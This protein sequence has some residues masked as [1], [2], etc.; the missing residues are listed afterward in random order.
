MPRHLLRPASS[1]K[2][3]A[4]SLFC[5]LCLCS[6]AALAGQAPP[7]VPLPPAP[8]VKVTPVPLI[9]DWRPY[10]ADFQSPDAAKREAAI[11]V[12]LEQGN[13]GVAALTPL[14][15]AKEPE[16]AARA[17]QVCQD[18]AQRAMKLGQDL[19]VQERDLQSKP[20]TPAAIEELRQAWVQLSVYAPQEQLRR[21][22][23]SKI[24]QMQGEL[25]ALEQAETELDEIDKQ[26][27]GVTG[28]QGLQ[29]A[30]LLLNRAN[31]LKTLQRFSDA[32]TTLGQVVKLSG[33]EGRL[34]P[35]A[36][37]D[38]AELYVA[39]DDKKPAEAACRQ[40]KQDFPRSLEVKFAWRFLIE[41][42]RGEKQWDE[43]EGQVKKFFELCPLDDDA[44]EVVF[45][46][47][48]ALT[49]AGEFKRAQDFALWVRQALPLERLTSDVINFSA[50]GYEYLARDYAKAAE[51]YTVLRDRFS[52]T[53]NA[54]EM[55]VALQ[56]LKAKSEQKFP[57][58]AAE[59][60]DGAAGAWARF[61][62]AMRAR[63]TQ[64]LAAAVPEKSA[65]TFAGLLTEGTDEL[66]S[67][68]TFGD[69]VVTKVTP[70]AKGETAELTI[71]QY[72]PTSAKPVVLTQKALKE[73]GQWK[74]DW[75][76]PENDR[77]DA[78]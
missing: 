29:C 10:V 43:A 20:L 78:E 11:K 17:K 37:K 66:L 35:G 44:Q 50:Q 13:P 12:F 1:L 65:E 16:V 38:Q 36:L 49:A 22:A 18:I 51:A 56:R 4:S 58:E 8:Q 24:A 40:I 68:L 57:K 30:A 72:L 63:D 25:Q 53:V 64:A 45:D 42:A 23:G 21:Y 9:A 71:D 69:Y 39:L 3:Q 61:V 5:V 41:Q 32:V 52:D 19:S 31:A 28:P 2:S 46:T 75:Q 62:K 14:L 77:D 54:E 48:N 67:Q 27:N 15:G 6:S 47:L 26:L 59:T 73:K 34:T 55:Q 60:D 70:D 7:A 33:K 76:A 74:I